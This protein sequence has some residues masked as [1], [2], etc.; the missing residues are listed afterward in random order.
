MTCKSIMVSDPVAARSDATVADAVRLLME[1]KIKVVPVV[2]AA[3][4]YQGVFGVYFLARLLLPKAALMDRGLGIGDLAFV[5]DSLEDLKGY[6]A[7]LSS[8]TLASVMSTDVQPLHPDDSL[9][10]T[11]FM[12][13]RQQH[14]LPVVDPTTGKLLGLVTFWGIL[15]A[16]GGRKG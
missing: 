16:L 9:S 2:D 15:E 1:H 8:R 5:H 13:Y 14:N 4:V 10:K 6:F 11:L 3:G 12:L 7:Q